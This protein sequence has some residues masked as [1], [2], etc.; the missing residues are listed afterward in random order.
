MSSS[1]G[2]RVRVSLFGES[3]GRCVGCVIDGLPA[4]EAIDMDEVLVQ[5]ERRAPGRDK[6]ATPRRES[7]V[8]QILSGCWTAARRAPRSL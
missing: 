2:D 1:I 6:T 4:G 5:M 8:P 3:H 7:D